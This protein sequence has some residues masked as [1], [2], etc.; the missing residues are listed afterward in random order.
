MRKIYFIAI[1]ALLAVP[2]CFTQQSSTKSEAQTSSVLASP[3]KRVVLGKVTSIVLG[4]VA[5]GTATKIVVKDK[6]G[7][8]HALIITPT[9]AFVDKYGKDITLDQILIGEKVRVRYVQTPK[10]V[11]EVLLI[12]IRIKE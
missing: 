11:K 7:K 6:S 8:E 1:A 4:D 9:T 12:R 5:R 2:L 10:G 3:Q